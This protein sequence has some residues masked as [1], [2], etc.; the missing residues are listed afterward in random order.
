MAKIKLTHFSFHVLFPHEWKF[1]HCVYTLCFSIFLFWWL[2]KALPILVLMSSST[3]DCREGITSSFLFCFPFFD[4]KNST[5][6]GRSQRRLS[7]LDYSNMLF[8]FVYFSTTSR[9]LANYAN[10]YVFSEMRHEANLA[11]LTYV[12]FPC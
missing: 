4:G 6:K 2:D 8:I 7:V 12:K 10:Y 9:T 5:L 3:T 1:G 11:Q